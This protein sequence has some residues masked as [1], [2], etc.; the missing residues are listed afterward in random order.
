MDRR[1]NKQLW[2]IIFLA[3]LPSAFAG[4]AA[5]P[6][7]RHPDYSSYIQNLHT[8]LVLSPEVNLF[9]E[10]SDGK[11]MPYEEGSQEA[12]AQI[13]RALKG[14]L[15]AKHV[16]V[17]TAEASL[18]EDNDAVSV[19]RLFRAVNRSIQLHTYGPQF[20][21]A[22]L[23][24]FEY[25]VGPVD[26][27]LKKAGADALVLVMGHQT[28]S[29]AQPKTWLS[30]ALIEAQGHIVWYCMQGAKEDLKIQS[31]A[32]AQALVELTLKHFPGGG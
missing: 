23:E 21:P 30:I 15:E 19:Q 28:E 4:C 26:L 7:R 13:Q 14:R 2:L 17:K 3:W 18:A 8:V 16:A 24:S 10:M 6:E 1:Q 25:E 12:R 20:F 32:G 11:V 27:L 5:A 9:E 29:T 31:M 22:K